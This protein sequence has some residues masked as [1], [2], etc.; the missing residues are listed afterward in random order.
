LINIDKKL[1]S[2]DKKLLISKYFTPINLS[3]EKQK[4]IKSKGEY[5]PV[6]E[7]RDITL[8]FDEIESDLEKIEIND[9]PLASIYI[10]KKEEIL[11]KIALFKAFKENDARDITFYS[12]KIF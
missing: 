2:I 3:E 7:Y 8:D 12:K 6:F 4:F 5:I 10:R 9:I 11:N 1:I